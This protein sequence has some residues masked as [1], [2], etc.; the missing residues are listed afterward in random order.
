MRPETR[1]A[2][3]RVPGSEETKASRLVS[4]KER[5]KAPFTRVRTNLCTDKNLHSS[6][7]RFHGTGRTGR[8]FERLSVQIW[9]LK[10]AGQLF[11]RHGS[12]FE[13]TR[14][15]TRIVQLFA[16]IAWLWPGIKRHNWSK[17]CTDPCKHHYNRICPDPCK[18]AVQEQN[19]S[20]QTF[21]RTLCERGLNVA[22]QGQ[23]KNLNYAF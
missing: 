3:L 23:P 20:V 17:L 2:T 15:N 4:R 5:N 10:K 13:R 14:A 18:Q 6:T 7:L 21:V 1:A 11:D 16:Q 8:I 12:I 19:S 22:G 9:D